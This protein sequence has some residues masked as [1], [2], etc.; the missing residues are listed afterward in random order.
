MNLVELS[1]RIK[2]L[3]VEHGMTLDEVAQLSGQ[4]RSW[5]SK[6]ENFRVTPS[7]PALGRIAQALGV[8]TSSL[9]EGLDE[10]PEIVL[11]RKG[12][13]AI[14]ERD[15]PKSTTIYQSLANERGNRAMDP[16]LLTVPPGEERDPMPHEGEEFLYVVKGKVD[17]LYGDDNF[18]LK[19]GDSLY[20]D[21]ERDH[22][23]ANPYKSDAKVLCV[24]RMGREVNSSLPGER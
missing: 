14:V 15:R 18:K 1:Q 9:L 7:L 6:V 4:S 19:A 5:M 20:F 22:R 16:F 11:V 17:F 21:S 10:K 23:L 8:S 13:G 12:E 2:K 24:F 3:R